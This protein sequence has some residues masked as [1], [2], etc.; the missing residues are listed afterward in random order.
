MSRVADAPACPAVVGLFGEAGAW[1]GARS[2]GWSGAG[3]AHG[4]S[5]PPKH[6]PP[7]ISPTTRREKARFRSELSDNRHLVHFLETDV[8]EAPL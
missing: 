6:R 2:C 4:E 5:S 8:C 1:L 3:T 7:G